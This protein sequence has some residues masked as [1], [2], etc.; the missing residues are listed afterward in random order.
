MKVKII[1]DFHISGEVLAKNNEHLIVD[2]LEKSKNEVDFIVL[3]G[4]IFEC[5][6]NDYALQEHLFDNIKKNKPF[7]FNYIIDN[8]LDV[9]G[10]SFQLIP[11]IYKKYEHNKLIYINGNHDAIFRKKMENKVCRNVIFL[12]HN[13]KIF[14]AHGH[15]VDVFNYKNNNCC[16]NCFYPGGPLKTSGPSNIDNNVDDNLLYLQHTFNYLPEKNEIYENHACEL[17][18]KENY[19]I[20]VYG[21]THEGCIK[22]LKNNSIYCNSGSNICLNNPHFN[23][24]E[25]I[26]IDVTHDEVLI[27]HQKTSLIDFKVIYIEC[28]PFKFKETTLK[29]YKK[30]T[31]INNNTTSPKIIFPE[32]I[33]PEIIL[34]PKLILPEII[35]P[36]IIIPKKKL[37]KKKLYLDNTYSKLPIPSLKNNID[38][39]SNIHHIHDNSRLSLDIIDDIS[40][41]HNHRNSRL[42]LD[43]DLLRLNDIHLSGLSCPFSAD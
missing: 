1:S 3:N 41:F 19:D 5:W 7:F 22:V 37:H 20:V 29:L 18:K 12:L 6:A 24:I 33:S 42:S 8:L 26:F 10:L 2:Y 36:E 32:I 39:T 43:D 40:H 38:T 9:N 35:P 13:L 31:S 27:Y 11:N 23:Y 16:F 34:H 25:E 4:D 21:H 14:I 17:S 15:D 28:I 30:K